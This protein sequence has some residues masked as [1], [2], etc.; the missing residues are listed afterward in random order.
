MNLQVGR[1]DLLRLVALGGAVAGTGALAAC[2]KAD[3]SG[4]SASASALPTSTI[5]TSEVAPLQ[6]FASSDFNDE[7]PSP[8]AEQVRRSPKLAR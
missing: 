1:R 5:S 2:A 4:A 3:S 8:L 7:A 6:L